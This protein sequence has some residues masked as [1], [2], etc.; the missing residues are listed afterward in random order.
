MSPNSKDANLE[1]KSVSNSK[2]A[3]LEVIKKMQN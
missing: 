1:S 3:N 2:D